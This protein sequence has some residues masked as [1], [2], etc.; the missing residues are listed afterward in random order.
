METNITYPWSESGKDLLKELQLRIDIYGGIEKVAEIIEYENRT[1][2]NI[3]WNDQET[4]ILLDNQSNLC[5][6]AIHLN[7]S[8]DAVK[9][10]LDRVKKQ[11]KLR[12][13]LFK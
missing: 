11:Q 4:K 3:K 10:R 5:W 6:V 9:N 2:N 13:E 7:R 12:Q 1:G 8:Y